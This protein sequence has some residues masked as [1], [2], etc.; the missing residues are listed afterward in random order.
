MVRL[1]T[2]QVTPIKDRREF[3]RNAPDSRLVVAQKLPT[4]PLLSSRP[5]IPPFRPGLDLDGG[6]MNFI[7]LRA[8]STGRKSIPLPTPV[9]NGVRRSRPQKTPKLPYQRGSFHPPPTGCIILPPS[10]ADK[11]SL[12]WR[13]PLIP[14]CILMPA[15]HCAISPT[16][17]VAHHYAPCAVP[18]QLTLANCYL[19]LVLW[20][21]SRSVA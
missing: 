6:L 5:A 17:S 12:S 15:A 7:M 2:L 9:S 19:S 3:R 20:S 14:H 13:E 10:R 21:L 11:L 8:P 16:S 1:Y 4:G 18:P